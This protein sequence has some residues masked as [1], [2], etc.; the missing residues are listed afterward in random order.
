MHVAFIGGTRFIGRAA[1]REA[2]E[3]GHTVS[4]LHRGEHACDLRG[5]RDVRVDRN[6][7]S[8]LSAALARLAP[9][10]VVDTR[11]MTRVDAQVTSL[12]LRVV[13]VPGVVL[14]SMDVYAQFGRLNGLPAPEPEAVVTESSP[15]TIPFPFRGIA[16]DLGPDYDKKEVEAELE[17]AVRQG[18][19]P[20]TVL[21]LPAVYGDGDY[22]RRLAGVVARIDVGE[23][24]F[25]CV[26]GAS[27]RQ[28]HAHVRDVAHAI[29]LAAE[30]A[31]SGYAVFNVGERETPTMRA[32][33]EAIARTL[34]VSVEWREE[35]G[36]LV[37]ELSF[38]G[39]MPNDFVV[40]TAALR[41][42]LGFDELTTE[43]ERLADLID[44]SR[45]SRPN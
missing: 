45:R 25:P 20:V 34:D 16:P 4:V 39:A 17:S 37:D 3:R 21:R 9:D 41:A 10:V 12:A 24:I 35:S 13:G 6:D 43:R 42:A 2:L 18:G 28:S 30:R 5:V 11:A 32:R 38:L 33:V 22:R 40:S 23:R 8:A 14:S 36:E 44:W 1:A 26:S 27:W 19:P 29:L 15:L 7:P 31:A